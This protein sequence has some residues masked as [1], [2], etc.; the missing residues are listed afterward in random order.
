MGISS[1]LPPVPSLALGSGEVTLLE[2]TAAYT[3]FANNGLVAAPRMVTRVEDTSGS[4]LFE[5]AERRR[6]AI[7]PV[8]AYLMSNML[9]EVIS[10]GSANG[11]RAAGFKLPAAGK[12]GTTNDYADAWFVGYTPGLVAGV[13]FGLDRPAPIM[14]GGFASVV[15][16]PA[17]A[18]FMS[19]ATEGEKPSWYDRPAGIETVK[20]C[21]RS[22]ARAVAACE[23]P[24]IVPASIVLD[25]TGT[26]VVRP[27]GP[28]IPADEPLV[29]EDM[30][31][32]GSAP[33]EDCQGH[34]ARTHADLNRGIPNPSST[35]PQ[36]VNPE[37]VNPESANRESVNR[38][39]ANPG[40]LESLNRRIGRRGSPRFADSRMQ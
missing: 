15:A 11:V 33:V 36:S 7:S 32:A 24:D 5:A 1:T 19:A 22:G 21:R 12:T 37:S 9:A 3:A 6:Q 16:V 10:R 2:L 31:P 4:V 23:H 25:A 40:I 26:Y 8:T 30:F 35:N 34:V 28:A 38:E 18:S 17:W 13:W 39:S 27:A 20:I 29:Y 14:R